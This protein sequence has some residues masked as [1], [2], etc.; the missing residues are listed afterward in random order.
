M[1]EDQVPLWAER[2]RVA[3]P[4]KSWISSA[5]VK[6]IKEFISGGIVRVGASQQTEANSLMLGSSCSAH[7]D[8]FD[9]ARQRRPDVSA[10]PQIY[11]NEENTGNLCG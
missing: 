4:T 7:S 6:L 1:S 9:A 8:T 11:P 10:H 5:V 2:Y 3:P